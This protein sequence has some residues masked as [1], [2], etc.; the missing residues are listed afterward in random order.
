MFSANETQNMHIYWS[1]SALGW[2]SKLNAAL[3]RSELRKGTHCLTVSFSSM[4]WN[5]PCTHT[6]ISGNSH[7]STK[8][9]VW[10]PW[11]YLEVLGIFMQTQSKY[12]SDLRHH[13]ETSQSSLPCWHHSLLPDA[14]TGNVMLPWQF[15][16]DLHGHQSW[17][18][19]V[20][21]CPISK[22]QQ[23]KTFVFLHSCRHSLRQ[24]NSPCGECET[25]CRR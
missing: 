23:R 7:R 22:P 1:F 3:L 2:M 5:C 25:G 14:E 4:K 9:V 12:S 21:L 18:P 11:V 20:S 13:L 19:A 8:R 16:S 15:L 17:F 24:A 10:T 6:L